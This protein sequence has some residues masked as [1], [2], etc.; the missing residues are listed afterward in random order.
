MNSDNV[1]RVSESILRILS[2]FKRHLDEQNITYSQH[3]IRSTKLSL[4]SGLASILFFIH[5]VFPFIFETYGSKTISS[6]T[7]D[8]NKD[9][10]KESIIEIIEN[11]SL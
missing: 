1:N 3:F 5:A 8:L 9:L 4:R 11:K 2:F 7:K 10:N 6:I